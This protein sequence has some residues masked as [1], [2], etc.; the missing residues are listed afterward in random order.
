MTMSKNT[1]Y[2]VVIGAV[3]IGAYIIM[4]GDSDILTLNQTGSGITSIDTFST[5]TASSTTGQVYNGDLTVTTIATDLSDPAISY[6]GDTEFTTICYKDNNSA[7]VNDWTPIA[8]ATGANPEV[9]TI[10]VSK[11]SG[12]DK[13]LTQMYCD[14]DVASAQDYY[15]V[16]DSLIKDNSRISNAIFDDANGD[17]VDSWIYQVN[18]LDVSPADPNT[19]PSLTLFYKLADEGSLTVSDPDSKASVGQGSVNNILKFKMNMDNSG[20]AESISQIQIRLNSTD[21]G[22]WF[23][24]LSTVTIAGIG[25]IKFADMVRSDLAS[26]TVYK[27]TLG[28]DYSEGNM[29]FVDKNGDTEI[30]AHVEIQ[31]NFDAS[32]E[33]L[34]VE[35]QVRTVDAQGAYTSSSADAEIAEGTNTDECTL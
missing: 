32:N 2:A 5:N 28:S 26:T 23:E 1:K 16:K 24:N 7:D 17:N 30:D 19:T 14:I 29:V 22:Q 21:D 15:V 34:C 35:L 4:Q 27:Y 33:G 20:D 6:G 31:S 10:P 18:L 8:T 11:S 25:E 9:L 3:I 13:G 12:N